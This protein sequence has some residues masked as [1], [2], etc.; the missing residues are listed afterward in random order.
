MIKCHPAPGDHQ[1]AT[2]FRRSTPRSLRLARGARFRAAAALVRKYASLP[3]LDC[4]S[5]RHPDAVVRRKRP[6]TDGA[7]R[8]IAGRFGR[9]CLPSCDCA[10]LALGPLPR[11]AGEGLIRRAAKPAPSALAPYSSS[12]AGRRRAPPEGGSPSAFACPAPFFAV[13]VCSRDRPFVRRRDECALSPHPTDPLQQP[14]LGEV[15]L[16][17]RPTTACS[18]SRQQDGCDRRV[19]ARRPADA[20]AAGTESDGGRGSSAGVSSPPVRHR[21]LVFRC[22]GRVR[23]RLH[24]S[25]LSTRGGP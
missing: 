15:A 3:G 6:A 2:D 24:P 11:R 17:P 21:W 10:M 1:R 14:F 23:A 22:A 5:G 8:R 18:S 25:G 13:G 19:T 4:A 7:C 12:S 20:D 9:A 16:N